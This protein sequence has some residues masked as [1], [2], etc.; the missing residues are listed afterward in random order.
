VD[1]NALR[2]LVG[3]AEKVSREIFQ[4][5]KLIVTN[6]LETKDCK[7]DVSLV[8]RMSTKIFGEKMAK[9]PKADGKK[10]EFVSR[11]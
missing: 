8:R 5:E 2:I 11:E 9:S 1:F 7:D 3:T 10:S 4:V 6:T